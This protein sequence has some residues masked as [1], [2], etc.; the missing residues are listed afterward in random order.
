MVITNCYF[1]VLFDFIIYYIVD[2]V[3][4]KFIFYYN[5]HKNLLKTQNFI[6]LS[7]NFDL[8][9]INLNFYLYKNLRAAR[10]II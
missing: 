2:Y 1:Y 5:N 9:K 4:I 7:T 8:K 6:G 3:I 10:Y